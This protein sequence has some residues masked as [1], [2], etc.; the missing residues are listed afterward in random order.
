MPLP[1]VSAMGM[2][3]KIICFTMNFPDVSPHIAGSAEESCGTAVTWGSSKPV[4]VANFS[5]SA[6]LSTFFSKIV[7]S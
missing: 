2:E 4:S 1:A 6:R 3:G 7:L 5:G